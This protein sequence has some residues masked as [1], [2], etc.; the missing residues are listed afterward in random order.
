MLIHA[1]TWL[2]YI[3]YCP[4]KLKLTILDFKHPRSVHLLSRDSAQS[5]GTRVNYYTASWARALRH[6]ITKDCVRTQERLPP[7][8]KEGEYL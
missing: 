2:S 7:E 4:E 3:H 6:T 8:N 1:L 5:T